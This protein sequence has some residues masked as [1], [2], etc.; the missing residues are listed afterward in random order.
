MVKFLMQLFSA[1][2]QKLRKAEEEDCKTI[3]KRELG[4]FVV[5]TANFCKVKGL[6]WKYSLIGELCA[7]I[8]SINHQILYIFFRV[9]GNFCYQN[10]NKKAQSITCEKLQAHQ[11]M[12]SCI[13]QVCSR[14]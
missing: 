7:Y 4:V 5:H 6:L 14:N 9:R 1:Y 8:S 11:A 13:S 12:F 3:E 2:H 10:A